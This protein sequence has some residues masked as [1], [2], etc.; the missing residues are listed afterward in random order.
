MLYNRK[1]ALAVNVDRVG[2][3]PMVVGDFLS[4]LVIFFGLVLSLKLQIELVGF[5]DRERFYIW[6]LEL[7]NQENWAEKVEITII[8][9]ARPD[10]HLLVFQISYPT[11]AFYATELLSWEKS[12]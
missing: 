6:S 3:L 12:E 8:P 1:H 7:V 11:A 2:P 9:Y 10:E 5:T 4:W